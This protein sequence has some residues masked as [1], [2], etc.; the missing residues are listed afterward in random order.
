[1]KFKT[2]SSGL[3]QISEEGYVVSK[4]TVEGKPVYTAWAPNER[5]GIG[6]CKTL[7]A[8]HK[9]CEKHKRGNSNG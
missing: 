7:E 1:M 2:H 4:A 8:A 9:C 5:D 3:W 6:Y